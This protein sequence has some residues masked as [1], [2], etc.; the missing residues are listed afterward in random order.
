[1]GCRG[2]G[3]CLRCGAVA[4]PGAAAEAQPRLAC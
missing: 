1:M 2:V 4:P 3:G